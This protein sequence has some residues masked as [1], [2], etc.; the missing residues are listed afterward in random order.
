MDPIIQQPVFH[1]KYIS[2]FFLFKVATF[3]V[4]TDPLL[5]WH[6]CIVCEETGE[7]FWEG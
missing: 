4:A 7:H 1:G 5:R 6:F 2:E 3:G